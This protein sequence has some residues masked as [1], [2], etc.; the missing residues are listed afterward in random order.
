MKKILI[1]ILSIILML[2]LMGCS[3]SSNAEAGT[4]VNTEIEKEKSESVSEPETDNSSTAEIVQTSSEDMFSSRDLDWT[5]D[6]SELIEINLENES[7][8]ITTEGVYLITGSLEN[9]QIIIDAADAD[10]VQ[11]V[12]SGVSIT[13]DYSAPIYIKNADKVFITLADGTNNTLSISGDISDNVDSVD[14]VIYSKSDL[15]FNGL[16][17]LSINT[18]YTHGIVGKDDVVFAGGSYH[19]TAAKD[20]I[21]ANDSVKTINSDIAI[22]SE[23]DG[24]QVSNDENTDK[25]FIYFE[26]STIDLETT[27]DAVSASNYVY[28]VSGDYTI[29]SASDGISADTYV[30]ITGGNFDIKTGGGYQGVLNIITMGEG[31]GNTVSETDKLTVSMKAIKG[32][33]IIIDGGELVISSYEDGFNA[34]NDITISGGIINMNS[35]DDAFSAKNLLEIN[36]GTIIVENGYEGLEGGYITINGGDI[37]INVLDDGINGGEDYSLVTITGGNLSVTCQGDGLDSNGDMLISG[38][39]IVL[40]VDAIYAGGDGNVDVSGTLT[41]TGGTIVDETGASIDPTQHSTG[42]GGGGTRGG[43]GTGGGRGQ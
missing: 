37:T 34:N 27:E 25:G 33:D 5:Y 32:D 17:T 6:E 24:I 14:G 2:S 21:Q 1:P 39:S 31:S 4:E 18:D 23:K 40:D 3:N 28:I 15:T 41:Y 29:N 36:D 7:Q 9:G 20:G 13:S 35:G 8:T 38:G 16:G 30:Q 11:L 42:M 26:S 19:I 12:L 43:G 22:I 10:K